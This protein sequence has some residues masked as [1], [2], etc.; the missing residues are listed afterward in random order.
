M[1][2]K[3]SLQNDRN[4]SDN[5]SKRSVDKLK[6]PNCQNEYGHKTFCDSR[7]EYGVICSII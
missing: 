5:R 2:Q 3:H 1:L 7:T 6:K 4:M